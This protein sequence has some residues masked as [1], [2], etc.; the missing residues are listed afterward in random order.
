M[1]TRNFLIVTAAV[2]VGAGLA[3]AIA[4]AVSVGM[5]LGSTPVA[6]E[7]MIVGRITGAAL[8]SLGIACWLAKDDER[9]PA[10]TGLIVAL[11]FYNTGA[12]AILAN[13]GFVSERVGFILWPGVILHSALAAWCIACLRGCE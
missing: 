9:S 13:T 6:S 3:M 7:V 1:R 8:F 5:L 10:A 4:P 2:E 12:V 11:L